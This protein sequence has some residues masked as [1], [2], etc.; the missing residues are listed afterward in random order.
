MFQVGDI[1]EYVV[2]GGRHKDK[3][4]CTV[5]AVYPKDRV[6]AEFINTGKGVYEKG[7]NHGRYTFSKSY[8]K[9]AGPIQ[10]G[11]PLPPEMITAR[12]V[13]ERIEKLYTRQKYYCNHKLQSV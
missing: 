1:V 13:A 4:L 7:F 9:L 8:F 5:T 11:C 12:K 3:Y 6:Q 10:H 2:D